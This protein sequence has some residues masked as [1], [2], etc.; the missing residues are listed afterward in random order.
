MSSP[1]KSPKQY[2]DN[3]NLPAQSGAAAGR[4]ERAPDS[5]DECFVRPACKRL[6]KKQRFG[7][8]K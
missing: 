1:K 8:C 4:L 6:E 7:T 2:S 5:Q 3:S